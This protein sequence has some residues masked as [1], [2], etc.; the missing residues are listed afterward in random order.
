MSESLTQSSEVLTGATDKLFS[1]AGR[2]DNLVLT[3]SQETDTADTQM[4]KFISEAARSIEA[5]FEAGIANG[6]IAEEAL[7]D[8]SYEPIPNTDPE[9][10]MAPFT[11]F[12]DRVLPAIQEDILGRS[13]RIA[14]CVATDSNCYVPTHNREVSQP[15]GPD[16]VWN[17]ANCRNQRFFTNDSVWR[18]VKNE[19]PLLL[20]TYRR[21]MGGGNFILMKEIS[22]PLRVC[23]RKWGI[24]RMGYQP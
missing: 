4:A 1:V 7:F 8:Q 17:A 6:D 19:E 22:A 12:T 13:E 10:H 2:S 18:A 21:D 16:P 20:Q 11:A 14:Y 23:R 15:Q 9:Q 3:V 5:A 24:V